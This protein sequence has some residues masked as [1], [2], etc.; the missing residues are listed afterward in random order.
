MSDL[1]D[2]IDSMWGDADPDAS[3]SGG[4]FGKIIG[5][6]IFMIIMG[7]LIYFMKQG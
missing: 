5:W 3:S 2:M 7:V 1:G 6:I 4:C